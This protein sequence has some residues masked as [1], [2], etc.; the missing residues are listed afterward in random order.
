MARPRVDGG[1]EY[2]YINFT[3]LRKRGSEGFCDIIKLRPGQMDVFLEEPAQCLANLLD[4]LAHPVLNKK[5]IL[6]A[7]GCGKD[8]TGRVDSSNPGRIQCMHG[9]E[10][11]EKMVIEMAHALTRL[12]SEYFVR[13]LVFRSARYNTDNPH[14]RQNWRLWKI[15]LLLFLVGA[16]TSGSRQSQLGPH[17]A[18]RCGHGWPNLGQCLSAA[19]RNQTR[20]L[21]RHGR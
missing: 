18:S 16:A 11:E 14:F 17:R 9:L 5:W 4:A 12:R 13:D 6:T 21:G 19:P 7:D 8:C 15:K 10:D 2:E 20:I 3:I 1:V